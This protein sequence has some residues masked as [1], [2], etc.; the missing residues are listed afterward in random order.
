VKTI[1]DDISLTH[2]TNVIKNAGGYE[3]TLDKIRWSM[4]ESGNITMASIE[5]PLKLEHI[6]GE[7]EPT[8]S[9]KAKSQVEAIYQDSVIQY[10]S[11]SH[12][13]L[14]RPL[15]SLM[16]QIEAKIKGK[17]IVDMAHSLGHLVAFLKHR[18]EHEIL[19][20]LV[21]E[22]TL[23]GMQTWELGV[24]DTFFKYEIEG[25]PGQNPFKNAYEKGQIELGVQGY[26]HKELTELMYGY[27]QAYSK[28]F[29]T[30][31]VVLPEQNETVEAYAAAKYG[32]FKFENNAENHKRVK[33][34]EVS[35]L[36]LFEVKGKSILLQEKDV[37]AVKALSNPQSV[38]E[39]T[40]RLLLTK[41]GNKMILKSVEAMKQSLL[42]KSYVAL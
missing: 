30:P 32:R 24:R 27:G 7:F 39:E 15:L 23:Y 31:Q 19:G 41:P 2:Y 25:R 33:L 37:E 4:L 22:P 16:P 26:E 5:P 40:M 13:A 11:N 38:G 36:D 28:F 20:I 14:V 29:V 6:R 1:F 12:H 17:F 21:V 9:Y 35:I 8:E 3:S 42:E 34:S 18:P 10:L